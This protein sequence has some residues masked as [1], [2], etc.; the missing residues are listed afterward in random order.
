M[1]RKGGKKGGTKGTNGRKSQDDKGGSKKLDRYYKPAEW[2][3]L[4]ADTRKKVIELRKKRNI[5]EI[6]SKDK[7]S[8][9]DNSDS[10]STSQRKSKSK[11]SVKFTDDE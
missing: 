10:V 7:S 11:K 9:E 5:S 1:N 2:W 8:K 3:K 4:D 6:S